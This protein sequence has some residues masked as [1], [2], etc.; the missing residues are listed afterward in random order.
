MKVRSDAGFQVRR[1]RESQASIK[2]HV[3]I[4]DLQHR[5]KHQFF[6]HLAVDE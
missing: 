3:E 5:L 1:S 2:Q 6:Q 4:D